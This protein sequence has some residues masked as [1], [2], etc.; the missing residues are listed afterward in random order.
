MAMPLGLDMII[1]SVARKYEILLP[2]HPAVE[3]LKDVIKLGGFDAIT[4]VIQ[5]YS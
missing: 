3:C 2:D 1:G 5:F 4:R